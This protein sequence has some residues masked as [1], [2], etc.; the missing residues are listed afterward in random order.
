MFSSIM[1]HCTNNVNHTRGAFTLQSKNR[2]FSKTTVLGWK[3][4]GNIPQQTEKSLFRSGFFLN[5]SWKTAVFASVNGWQGKIVIFVTW[6]LVLPGWASA[7]AH[8]VA[9][10]LRSHEP[11]PSCSNLSNLLNKHAQYRLK[12]PRFLGQCKWWDKKPRFYKTAVFA[13]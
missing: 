10:K 1:T 6:P 9:Y 11:A 2:G 4:L 3:L 5:F 12:K 7:S 13:G 8:S